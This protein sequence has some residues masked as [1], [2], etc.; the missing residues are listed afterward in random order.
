MNKYIIGISLS[1]LTLITSGCNNFLDTY[2]DNRIVLTKE[3]DVK[4]L[5]NTAY[6]GASYIYAAEMM[7]DNMIDLANNAKY[8]KRETHELF[9]WEVPTVNFND[10]PTRFWQSSYK[11]ITTANEALN[12]LQGLKETEMTR[13]LKSEALLCRAYN[14]FNVANM[15]CQSYNPK[16]ASTDMGIPYI[17]VSIKKLGYQG[18]RSTL[19]ETY[20][21]IDADIQAALPYVNDNVYDVPKYHFNKKAANALATRFYLFYQKW[22]KVVEYANVVLGDNPKSIMRD[23]QK[24][25]SMNAFSE[26]RALEY[27]GPENKANLMTICI[28]SNLSRLLGFGAPTRY[29]HSVFVA[30]NLTCFAPAAWGTSN[31]KADPIEL[32]EPY[33][34]VFFRKYPEQFEVRDAVSQT[35]YMHTTYPAFTTEEVL[36]SRAEAYIHLGEYDKAL[37]DMNLWLS[38]IM[39]NVEPLTDAKIEEW[40]KAVKLSRATEPTPRNQLSNADFPIADRKQDNYLQVVLHMRRIETLQQGL[41]WFDVKRYGMVIQRYTVNENGKTIPSEEILQVRDLRRAVQLPEEVI[42][43]GLKANPR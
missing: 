20:K 41:R 30:N 3:T 2:P 9:F 18:D 17:S 29:V 36:L 33:A 10:S 21:K 7:G 11:A 43:A 40:N 19:E 34:W 38:N 35:G 15:Y 14:H 4:K 22:D 13:G 6:P 5:L 8:D 42:S 39:K 28:A 26:E 32:V 27:A 23:W 12:I 1:V 16:F 24:Y 37:E 31:Y 25:G